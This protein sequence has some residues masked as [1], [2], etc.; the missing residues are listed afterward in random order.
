MSDVFLD[1][2]GTVGVL[3]MHS[4]VKGDSA[5]RL[6]ATLYERIVAGDDL[7]LALNQARIM[8]D[9][10]Q[11]IDLRRSWDWALPYLRVKVSPDQVLGKAPIVFRLDAEAGQVDEFRTSALFVGAVTERRHFLEMLQPDRAGKSNLIV[12]SG[13]RGIG[14]TTLIL[15]CLDWMAK[16]RTSTQVRRSRLARAFRRDKFPEA[17]L[18]GKQPFPDQ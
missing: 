14:K 9:Q 2:I 6:A 4:V 15:R 13:E 1:H 16:A 12:V 17:T 18:L 5:G 8:I 7:D 10:L 3:G 11:G